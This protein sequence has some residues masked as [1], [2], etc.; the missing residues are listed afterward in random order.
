[1]TKKVVWKFTVIA[2]MVL[3]AISAITPLEDQDFEQYM[4][5]QVTAELD[6]DNP[7]SVRGYQTFAAVVDESKL[8]M[9]DEQ[10]KVRAGDLPQSDRR[11]ASLYVALK[12]LGEEEGLDYAAYFPPPDGVW[13]TIASNLAPGIVKPG[14]TVREANRDKRNVFVLQRLLSHSKASVKRGLDLKGGVAFTLELDDSASNDV[15]AGGGGVSQLDKVIEIMN[16]RLNSFG[17]AETVVR[18]K[19][20]R[21]VEIQIPDLSTKEN[22]QII[23][24]L[25]RPALLE[26]KKVLGAYDSNVGAHSPTPQSLYDENG[27]IR[28]IKEDRVLYVAMPRD[29]PSDPSSEAALYYVKKYEEATGSII[30]QAYPSRTDSGGWEVS[31]DFTDEGSKEFARITGEIA[32]GNNPGKIGMLAIVLDGKL[33]SAPT[34]RQRINSKSARIEGNFSYA[35]AKA[36]ADVLNNPL[37]IPLKI[38]EMYEV[39]GTLA[40]D[41]LASSVKA[42]VLGALLVV[43]FMC[44][45]YFVGGLL[46]VLSVGVNVV[47]VIATM[48]YAD[49]TFTLPGIAAIVLTVGMAVDA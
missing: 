48:A 3:L 34:V 38:G 41:A 5:S 12:S 24:D 28:E 10:A 19:G 21:A 25:Q 33:E 36:L 44:V 43:V 18:K 40:D 39:A 45:Y 17:L 49:A 32:A 46:A 26:F 31:F 1:M 13:N 15:T 20:D 22:P 4:L 37:E 11:Y 42:C 27:K 35:D 8:R 14:V 23:E 47:L 30:E 6:P 7:T 2:A 9:Q 29:N 16:G